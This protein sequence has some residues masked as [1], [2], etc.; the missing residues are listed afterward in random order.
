MT[1]GAEV[2]RAGTARYVL[3]VL[4]IASDT[5]RIASIHRMIIGHED[6]DDHDATT[7]TPNRVVSVSAGYGQL[8]R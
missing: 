4:D 6:A 8:R 5:R 3:T 1:A 2:G 7:G